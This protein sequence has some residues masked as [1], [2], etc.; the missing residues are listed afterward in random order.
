MKEYWFWKDVP[1][2]EENIDHE[3]MEDEF[4]RLYNENKIKN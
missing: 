4:K 3:D 1:S 2:D